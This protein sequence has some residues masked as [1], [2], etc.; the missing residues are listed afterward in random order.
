[1]LGFKER[2]RK[3]ILRVR[4][5]INKDLNDIMQYITEL[6]EAIALIPNGRVRNELIRKRRIKLA[7]LKTYEKALD[8][9]YRLRD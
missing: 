2:R 8:R 3:R 9:Q 4:E 6:D 7:T 5:A 1:M